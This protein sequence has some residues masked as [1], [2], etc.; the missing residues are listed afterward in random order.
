MKKLAFLTLLAACAGTPP[1]V[2]DPPPAGACQV[3]DPSTLSGQSTQNAPNL[4]RLLPGKGPGLGAPMTLAQLLTLE[5]APSDAQWR[6]LPI[7]A[8]EKLTNIA[9]DSNASITDRARAVTGL[10]VRQAEGAGALLGGMV[11]N[12]TLDPTLRRTA[13]RALGAVGIAQGPGHGDEAGPLVG[14]LDDPDDL[15]REA[16]VQA[17]TPHVAAR[18]DIKAALEARQAKE[19]SPLVQRALTQALAPKEP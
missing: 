8:N 3:I 17:L 18:P 4:G 1:V 16:A 2:P 15:T 6:A 19:P 12:T 5:T 14:A 9:V 7:N 10:A 11:Q 13:I